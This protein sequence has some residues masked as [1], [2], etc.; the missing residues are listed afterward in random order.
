MMVQT[1]GCAPLL[2]AW[3]RMSGIELVEAARDRSRFMWPWEDV[4]VSLAHG[5][6]DDET[7]D[8]WE[9]VKGMRYTGGGPLVADEENL[10]RANTLAREYTGINVS[11]TGSAGLAGL[12]AA[13]DH[14]GDVAVIFSGAER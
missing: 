6:L 4:P 14:H 10:A 5:I 11:A 7:Y 9:A 13:G 12:L 3:Q 8:W 1:A 2:R